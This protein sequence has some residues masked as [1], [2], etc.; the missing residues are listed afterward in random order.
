MG[1]GSE[2]VA[3]GQDISEFQ[4][5]QKYGDQIAA[6]PVIW[7]IGKILFTHGGI[8]A[9]Q[10]EDLEGTPE[11]I[12][13]KLQEQNVNNLRNKVADMSK[14]PLQHD[15]S[16]PTDEVL[17]KLGVEH[18]IVGHKPGNHVRQVA[19]SNLIRVDSQISRAF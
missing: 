17:K 2:Y 7:K 18:V 12:M 5:G 14:Y 6:M 16:V 8:G 13:Q 19:N 11:Q 3:P 9:L 15:K 4:L 1:E 10:K